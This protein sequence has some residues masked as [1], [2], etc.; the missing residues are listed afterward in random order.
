[1]S[2]HLK[3]FHHF[4]AKVVNYLYSYSTRF[5]FFEGAGGVAFDGG[6]G[7]GVDFGFQGGFTGVV[8]IAGTEK[9]GLA[10]EKTFFIAISVDEPAGDTAGSVAD[11][12]TGLGFEHVHAIDFQSQF[13]GT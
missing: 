1:M 12:F 7:F 3:H 13:G 2:V 10:D 8:G 5:W 6:S 4:I 9:I 11:D